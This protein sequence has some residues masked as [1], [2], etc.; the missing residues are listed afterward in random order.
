MASGMGAL[1][2]IASDDVLGDVA[3]AAEDIKQSSDGI[4]WGIGPRSCH[5]PHLWRIHSLVFPAAVGQGAVC[6]EDNEQMSRAR[7]THQGGRRACPTEFSTLLMQRIICV[8]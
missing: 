5:H 6:I 4:Y 1:F 7:A 8:T 3:D 2:G